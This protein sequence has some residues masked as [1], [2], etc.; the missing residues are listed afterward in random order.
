MTDSISKDG[1]LQSRQWILSHYPAPN[2]KMDITRTFKLEIA[3]LR[4]VHPNHILVVTRY[5]A[6]APGLRILIEKTASDRVF[7]PVTECGE[8]VRI[9]SIVEVCQLP[10]TPIGEVS[11]L[12]PEIPRQR[13]SFSL[14]LTLIRYWSLPIRISGRE[15]CYMRTLDGWNTRGSVQRTQ[16]SLSH[17]F[18]PEVTPRTS[19]PFKLR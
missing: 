6:N 4:K 14:T 17:G 7:A 9:F 16:H 15:S 18:H 11:I 5:I 19:F 1:P 8:V 12:K 2:Q 10:K 3:P 13:W